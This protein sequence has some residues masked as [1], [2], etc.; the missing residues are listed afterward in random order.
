MADVKMADIVKLRKMTGAGMMDCKK[1]LE[2]ANSDFDKAVELI[3]EHGKAV[4][5]KRADREA[6]EGV[7]LASGCSC[8]GKAAIVTLNCETDFVAKN[9]DFIG[10][11]TKILNA[12]L[13]AGVKDLDSLKAM[14]LEGKTA[15]ALVQEFSGVTGEKMEL[16]FWALLEGPGAAYY[17]HPGNKLASIVVANKADADNVLMRD[18]A[19][20]IAGMNPV[21]VDA[22]SVPE[23]VRKKEYEIGREQARNEGRPEA[24]LDKIAEGRLQKYYKEN[25][26]MAQEFVKVGK[27]TVAQYIAEQ[28]KELKILSFARYSLQD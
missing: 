9:A 11:A 6:S 3:R 28:D 22:D 27:M 14:P 16:S 24:M 19:M 26:L 2:E 10:L 5:N 23:D 21:A 20:Q 7:V 4:A 1:A 13:E 15:D 8:V 18:V 12:G 17:I 25:T